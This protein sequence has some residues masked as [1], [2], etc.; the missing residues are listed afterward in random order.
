MTSDLG[1]AFGRAQ[2]SALY[3]S[4]LWDFAY[5]IHSLRHFLALEASSIVLA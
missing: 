4:L 3:V 1:K 5:C 2:Y